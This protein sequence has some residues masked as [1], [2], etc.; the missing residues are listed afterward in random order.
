MGYRELQ[1]T[2]E[3]DWN[4]AGEDR[5]PGNECVKSKT[6]LNFNETLPLCLCCNWHVALAVKLMAVKNRRAQIIHLTKHT[7][8]S[9]R[10][11]HRDSFHTSLS[12]LQRDLTAYSVKVNLCWLTAKEHLTAGPFWDCGETDSFLTAVL[13]TDR[14][15]RYTVLR[16]VRLNAF[17]WCLFGFRLYSRMLCINYF[18]TQCKYN[19]ITCLFFWR[20]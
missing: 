14:C 7:Q 13:S 10:A 15:E 20:N 18:F 2:A 5:E 12:E 1:P 6:A 4:I 11:F 17:G 8:V 16:L 3:C 9:M 19:L